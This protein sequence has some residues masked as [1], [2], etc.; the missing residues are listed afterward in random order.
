M[1]VLAQ[2]DA[3]PVNVKTPETVRALHGILFAATPTDDKVPEISRLKNTLRA[4]EPTKA[5]LPEIVVPMGHCIRA[6]NVRFPETARLNMTSRPIAPD[7]VRS[8]PVLR[9]KNTFRVKVLTKVRVAEIAWGTRRMAEYAPLKERL[10]AIP[11]LNMA[12]FET[13]PE[14]SA[15][16]EI[17]RLK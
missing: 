16:P 14:N 1:R 3:L 13:A 6:E 2:V 10:P 17:F 9:L 12:I 8:P 7:I 4:R 5:R 15:L 11:R